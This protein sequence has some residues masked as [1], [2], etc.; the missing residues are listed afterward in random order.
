M[1]GGRVA[2]ALVALVLGAALTGVPA[3]WAATPSAT[4][5]LR[6]TEQVLWAEAVLGEGDATTVRITFWAPRNGSERREL[7]QSCRFP[8]SGAGMYRCGIDVSPGSPGTARRGEWVAKVAVDGRVLAR[9]AF[10]L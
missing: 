7:W 9:R 10:R 2:T 4:L 3:A 8:F 1:R 6:R 5:D